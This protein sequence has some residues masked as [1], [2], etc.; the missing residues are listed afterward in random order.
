MQQLGQTLNFGIVYRQTAYRLADEIGMSSQ[1]A[2][3]LRADFILPPAVANC[4]A[5]AA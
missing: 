3:A 4:R 1:Q 5:T 2:E